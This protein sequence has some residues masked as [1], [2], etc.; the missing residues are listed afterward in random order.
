M[1]K[2]F[3]AKY[4][5]MSKLYNPKISQLKQNLK[6]EKLEFTPSHSFQSLLAHNE[7]NSVL[8]NNKTNQELISSSLIALF[9]ENIDDLDQHENVYYTKSC[10]KRMVDLL[11]YKS[12]KLRNQIKLFT[13]SKATGARK[14]LKKKSKELFV[15]YSADS[16]QAK[17]YVNEFLKENVNNFLSFFSY[18]FFVIFYF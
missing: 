15:S 17:I 10:C 3:E 5:S 4:I 14:L 13:F 7:T 9:N 16:Q 1:S 18:F 2:S 12:D 8:F 11:N 6:Y